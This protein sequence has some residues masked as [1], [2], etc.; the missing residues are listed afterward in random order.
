MIRNKKAHESWDSFP[1]GTKAYAWWGGFW[2]KT[3]KGWQW[4]GNADTFPA[5][6][7]ALTVN[8]PDNSGL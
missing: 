7:D 6:G 1:I 3:K 8:T 5:P 4:N 2:L